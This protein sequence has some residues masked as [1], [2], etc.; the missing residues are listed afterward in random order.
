MKRYLAV[1]TVFYSLLLS[2]IGQAGDL[3]SFIIF[4][5]AF[6]SAVRAQD[7]ERV[8]SM[9]NLPFYFGE[10]LDRDKYIKDYSRI[11][12]PKIRTCL[13]RE[14]PIPDGELYNVFCDARVFRFAKINGEWRLIESADMD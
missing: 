9:T 4:W 7:R 8:A 3:S 12:G 6:K 10:S 14:K 5:A 11:F 13:S 2:G 1:I